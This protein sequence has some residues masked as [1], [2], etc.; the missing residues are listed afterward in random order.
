MKILI[1]S[2]T[3]F[4]IAPTTSFLETHFTKKSDFVFEKKELEITVLITGVG[5]PFTSFYLGKMLA[6]NEFNLAINAGIAGAF[7]RNLKIGDVVNVISEQFG[8]LG[9]EESD[10]R[11]TDMHELDLISPNDFPFENGILKN[12]KA[13]GFDFLPKTKGLTVSKV[14]GFQPSIDLIR[15]KY[16]VDIESMEGGAFFLACKLANV[17]FLEIRSISNYVESRNRENWNI[18]SAIENLNKVLIEILKTF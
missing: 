4:E 11:F 7:D 2:A 1:V 5:I 13:V 10:G 16:N 17:P 12:E 14:H 6:Q 9:V 8:D 18:Q 3:P 15:K